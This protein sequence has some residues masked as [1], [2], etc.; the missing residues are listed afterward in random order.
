MQK[1]KTW[2]FRGWTVPL[3]LLALAVASFGL[4]IP[5][6]GLYWDDWSQLLVAKLWGLAAYWPYFASDR[7]FSAWTHVLFVPILGGNPL[8]WQIFSLALRW[9]TACAMAWAFCGLWPKARRQVF[10]AAILF[11]VYPAFTQQSDAVAYHQHWTQYLLFFLSLGAMVQAARRPK[12]FWGWTGLSLVTLVLHLSITEFFTGAELTRPLILWMLVGA[13]TDPIRVRLWRTFKRYLP[14]LAI[15]LVYVVW[16][17][18][19]GQLTGVIQHPPELL[20]QFFSNPIATIPTLVRYVV[21]DMLAI[22]V[23]SWANAFDLRLTETG[24]AIVFGSWLLSVAV[25]AGIFV[26]LSRLETAEQENGEAKTW[27]WQAAL[28]GG[29][30]TLL[31]PVPI[32]LTGSQLVNPD[33]HADRFAMVAMF[34]TALQ[35]VAAV[36]W[37]GRKQAQKAALLALLIGLA[38]GFHLRTA[39]EYRWMWTFQTRFYWQLA[40]RAP[41]LQSPTAIVA[42]NLFLPHQDLFSTSSALNVLYPQPSNPE[43]LAVWMYTL[44]PRFTTD[45]PPSGPMTFATKMR[46]FR[47]SAAIPKESIFVQYDPNKKRCMWVLSQRDRANPDISEL[48]RSALYISNLERIQAGPVVAGYPPTEY[49]GAELEHGWCYYFQKADLAAQLGDWAQVRALGDEA[50]AKGFRLVNPDSMEPRE[51]LPFVEGYARAETF[52]TARDLTLAIADRYPRYRAIYCDL[53]T[54]LSQDAANPNREPAA[55]MLQDLACANPAAGAP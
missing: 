50:Q 24:Q 32:W 15:L 52:S 23:G 33:F 7:P 1:L 41:A 11:L 9:L 27:M 19:F 51:W 3:A 21:V 25:A 4:R 31:G 29:L 53:W 34:G 30:V 36:E 45:N 17:L 55:G 13:G 2:I 37:F 28:L 18:F 14:Y 40:W 47:F 44:Q 48:T 35:F 38:A 6:L 16:R 43:R 46:T 22:L 8:H 42:E 20:F 39:N 5:K 49:F 26:Y 12:R 10:F 54:G